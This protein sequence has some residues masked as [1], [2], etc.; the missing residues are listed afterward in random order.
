LQPRVAKE[1]LVFGATMSDHM[2]EIDYDD[3]L[4][5]DAKGW[6]L[7]AIVPYHNLAIDPAASVLHYALEAFEG[8]KA[9]YDPKQKCVRLFRPDLNMARLARSM[10]RLA[11]P[12][13]PTEGFLKAIAR[14][15][16]E[17]K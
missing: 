4:E 17:E 15:V 12:Q 14:F 5:G 10:D 3:R 13:L 16:Q 1:K 8:M 11:M 9:F 7:P 6:S 2:L